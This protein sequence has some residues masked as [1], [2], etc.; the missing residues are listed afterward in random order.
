MTYVTSMVSNG[1][2]IAVTETQ[3]LY[4]TVEHSVGLVNGTGNAVTTIPITHTQVVVYSETIQTIISH[5]VTTSTDANGTAVTATSAV[6]RTSAYTM[7]APVSSSP[8][9]NQSAEELDDSANPNKVP[10]ST[11]LDHLQDK[12]GTGALTE[13]QKQQIKDEVDTLTRDLPL[14]AIITDPGKAGSCIPTKGNPCIDVRKAGGSKEMQDLA[15]SILEHR[16]VS[17]EEM[18]EKI[19]REQ[20]E[21]LEQP[22]DGKDGD[23]GDHGE[24]GKDDE[25]KEKKKKHCGHLDLHCSTGAIVGLALGLTEGVG[26]VT[27]A[28]II[29]ESR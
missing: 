20:P 27:A 16:G 13:Y 26:L 24:P 10:F 29:G 25:D 17:R 14:G 6:T 5:L 8:P 28:G 21:L 12:N 18:M 15:D 19:K 23:D 7:E 3:G 11:Y 9:S 4:T 22:E 1:S 2:T